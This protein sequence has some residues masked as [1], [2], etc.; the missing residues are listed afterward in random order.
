MTGRFLYHPV[1][2]GGIASQE[3]WKIMEIHWINQNQLFLQINMCEQAVFLGDPDSFSD[4]Q[5]LW[6]CSRAGF[7]PDEMCTMANNGTEVKCC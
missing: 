6:L 4:E 7:C 1:L 5:S 3:S 2:V